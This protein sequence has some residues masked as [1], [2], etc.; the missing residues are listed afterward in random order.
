MDADLRGVA[1]DALRLVDEEPEV[2]D[3]A[4]AG[5]G[6][7]ASEPA[8]FVAEDVPDAGEVALI[9]QREA[10]RAVGVGGEAAQGLGAVPIGPSRS[11][12]RWATASDSRP[13]ASTST[14]PSEKPTASAPSTP[15]NSRAV[16]AGRRQRSPGAYTCQT[17]SIF[18]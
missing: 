9:Q 18:R 2:G 12:P 5:A 11:G 15:S 10:D 4:G 14:L 3:V 17:P 16:N 13:R 7:D 1:E 8:R 6:V